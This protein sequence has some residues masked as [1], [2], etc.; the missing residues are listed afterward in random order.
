MMQ[1]IHTKILYLYI[2]KYTNVYRCIN[3]HV[4]FDLNFFLPSLQGASV[5]W[6]G[7][8]AL[9]LGVGWRCRVA[10]LMDTWHV[11]LQGI[12]VYQNRMGEGSR[13][14]TSLSLS[15]SHSVTPRS[16]RL[17]RRYGDVHTRGENTL[18]RTLSLSTGHSLHI[19]KSSS[20][21]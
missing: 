16:R 14:T 13:F 3:T 5:K 11:T 1:G 10:I 12:E 4:T 20:R 21:K 8:G 6:R 9:L 18:T 17:R 15:L 2:Y 19:H 7:Y